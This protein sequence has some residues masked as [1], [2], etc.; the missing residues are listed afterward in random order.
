MSEC[1]GDK[2]RTFG[3][4]HSAED[5][6]SSELPS[7]RVRSGKDN[8][9]LGCCCSNTNMLAA[10]RAPTSGQNRETER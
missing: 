3:P 9:H 4:L 2:A 1:V 8:H 10:G 5:V 6:T 7:N